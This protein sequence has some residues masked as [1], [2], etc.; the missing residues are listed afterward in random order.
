MI[1][2]IALN[3]DSKFISQKYTGIQVSTNFIQLM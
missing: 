1:N 3:I 2:E